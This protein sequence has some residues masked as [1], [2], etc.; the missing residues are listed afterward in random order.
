MSAPPDCCPSCFAACRS[1]AKRRDTLIAEGAEITPPYRGSAQDP[2][3]SLTEGEAGCSGDRV[4]CDAMSPGLRTAAALLALAVAGCTS[5]L[6]DVDAARIC[7]LAAASPAGGDNRALLDTL[8]QA[9]RVKPTDLRADKNGVFVP[10]ARSFV[11]ER[12]IYVAR[13]GA[14]LPRN[15]SDPSFTMVRECIYQYQIKG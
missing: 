1:S 15:G 5:D 10:Q 12:G 2:S 13:P 3:P 7:G 8:A 14:T 6:P 11:E 9:F 4:S